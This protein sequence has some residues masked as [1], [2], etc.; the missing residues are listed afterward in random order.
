M[1]HLKEI[2]RNFLRNTKW[3][4][5][6][7]KEQNLQG[8]LYSFFTNLEDLGY[9]VEMET[10]VKDNH[11]AKVLNKNSFK[12]TEIDLLIYKHDFS[13]KYA[14][15]LK[16]FYSPG[17]HYFDRFKEF[18]EDCFFAK[19][20]VQS[21]FDEACSVVVVNPHGITNANNNRK[22]FDLLMNFGFDKYNSIPRKLRYNNNE[23]IE[24]SWET[25]PGLSSDEKVYY[26][27]ISFSNLD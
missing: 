2:I 25:T 10:S 5:T 15:E 11:L 13:E 18:Q 26:Y 9:I 8:R 19:Q 20:L 12:K 14:V 16:W 27:I 24:F 17:F 6:N 4:N 22:N 7:E 1:I 23:D 21:G 3:C